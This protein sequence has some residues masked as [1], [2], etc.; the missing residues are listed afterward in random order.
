M[1]DFL[2]AHK[3]V[4]EDLA[5]NIVSE[6]C[7][8]SLYE[9]HAAIILYLL[10]AVAEQGDVNTE[11]VLHSAASLVNAHER[12]RYAQA[13]WERYPELAVEFKDDY[14]FANRLLLMR[15]GVLSEITRRRDWVLFA[16]IWRKARRGNPS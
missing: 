4:S 10:D 8:V 1:S 6:R 12:A 5:H 7:I 16:S 9:G 13:V 15:L 11:Y 2:K 14:D 3:I